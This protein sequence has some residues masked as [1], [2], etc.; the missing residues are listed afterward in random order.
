MGGLFVRT[1]RPG[2]HERRRHHR[3]AAGDDRARARQAVCGGVA[4]NTGLNALLGGVVTVGTALFV[5]FSP[6]FGGAVAGY[7]EGGH[8]DAGRKVGTLAGL[9]AAVP[10]LVV[11]LGLALL[12]IIVPPR[13]A[14]GVLL[15]GLLVV[16]LVAAYT[17]GLS[18]LGGVLGTYLEREL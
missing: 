12:P 18:A 4:P 1:R 9:V 2:G 7:L 14:V 13:G 10:L 16:V 8:G 11:L 3:A 17:I 6:V 5:P 15:V